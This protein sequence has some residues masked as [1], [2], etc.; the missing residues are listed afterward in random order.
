MVLGIVS[1]TLTSFSSF[2]VLLVSFYVMFSI[3]R[4]RRYLSLRFLGCARHVFCFLRRF[5][6]ISSDVARL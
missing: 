1:L 4:L 2:Q 3:S 5:F 6:K